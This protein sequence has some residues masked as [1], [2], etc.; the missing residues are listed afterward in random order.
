MTEMQARKHGYRLIQG[1]FRGTCDDVLDHWYIQRNGEIIRKIGPGHR[2]KKGALELL[3]EQIELE[4][5]HR[6][7]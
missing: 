7:S 6:N 1:A 2:T 3:A 4:K 5:E